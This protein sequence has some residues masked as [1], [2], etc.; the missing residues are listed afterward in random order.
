[1]VGDVVGEVQ[2]AFIKGRFILDGIFIANETVGYLK[3]NKE[4]GLIFKVDIEKAYDSINWAF[5]G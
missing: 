2:N 3:R 5:S 1:M 4:K